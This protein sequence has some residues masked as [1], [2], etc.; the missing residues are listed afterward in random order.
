MLTAWVAL[1]LYFLLS[2]QDY[3]LSALCCWHYAV[4]RP[5]DD[6]SIPTTLQLTG[7]TNNRHTRS[8]YDVAARSEYKQLS[9]L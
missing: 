8:S 1:H 7:N 2:W 5:C 6:A 4:G 9:H 3:M